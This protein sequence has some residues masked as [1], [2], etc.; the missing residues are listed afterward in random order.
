MQVRRILT[1]VDTHTA[2]GPTRTLI[3]GL[4]PLRGDSVAAK[5]EH[6]RSNYDPVRKL[7]MN[8]PAGIGTW[9]AR[10]SRS[11]PTRTPTSASFS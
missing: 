9:R 10:S 2:G 6:F 11:R 4:P 3:G 5:M 1:T 7:L 8:E